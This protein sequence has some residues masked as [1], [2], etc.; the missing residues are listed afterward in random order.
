[1]TSLLAYSQKIPVHANR[2][3]LKGLHSVHVLVPDAYA[4]CTHQFL[5]RTQ[6]ARLSSFH[7]CSAYASVLDACAQGMHKFPD[8]YAQHVL[9]GSFQFPYVRSVHESVPDSHA[10]CTHQFLT[11]MLSVRIN[12]GPECSE[13]ASVPD[14]YA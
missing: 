9:K 5:T 2:K 14:P 4:Q 3:L 12:S 13:Y 10:Q 8:T 1:M 6:S 11:H 7:V